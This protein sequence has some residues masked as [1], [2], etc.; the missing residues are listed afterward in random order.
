MIALFFLVTFGSTFSEFFL[1]LLKNGLG[2]VEALD[3]L[4]LKNLD[5]LA[6][7]LSHFDARLITLFLSINFLGPMSPL[8]FMQFKQ[9]VGMFYNDCNKSPMSFLSSHSLHYE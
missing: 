2:L 6:M 7:H 3:G 1:L 9:Y 4:F 5:L 8:S